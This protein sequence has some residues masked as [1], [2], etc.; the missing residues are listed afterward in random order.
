[1]HQR[2]TAAISPVHSHQFCR[3]WQC[4]G[5]RWHELS[6]APA[7]PC[8]QV[9]GTPSDKTAAAVVRFLSECKETELLSSQPQ[10]GPK[11]LRAGLCG[12]GL[13]LS[14]EGG[15]AGNPAAPQT[16]QL[17]SAIAVPSAL[18]HSGPQCSV[19]ACPQRGELKLPSPCPLYSP[20][21]HIIKPQQSHHGSQTP[22]HSLLS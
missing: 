20:S 1:M 8:Q 12:I 3:G 17:S 6:Q 13:H 7:S 5:R 11:H 4:T 9:L 18:W 21:P 14:T 22:Q 2:L 19:S 10:P 16:Q 15:L